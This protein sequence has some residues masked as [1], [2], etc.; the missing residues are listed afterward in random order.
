MS[1]YTND[2]PD[3]RDKVG[4]VLPAYKDA[5]D[6]DPFVTWDLSLLR[7]T[8]GNTDVALSVLNLLDTPPPVVRWE[9]SYDG[10]TH[11]PKGRRIKLSVTYRMGN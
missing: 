5:I 9:Q 8:S 4:N 1:G 6:I 10:F 3:F 11:N 2:N 7:R